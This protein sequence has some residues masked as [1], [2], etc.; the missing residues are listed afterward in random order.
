[1]LLGGELLAKGF[2]YRKL[3]VGWA[4]FSHNLWL[5][6][7]A[8]EAEKKRKEDQEIAESETGSTRLVQV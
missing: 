7:R 5:V 8:A 1:M 6:V 3:A 2:K 4:V